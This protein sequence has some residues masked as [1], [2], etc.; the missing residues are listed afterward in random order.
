MRTTSA[1][2]MRSTAKRLG[3]SVTTVSRAITCAP[4]VDPATRKRVL[5]EIS[6]QAVRP[7]RQRRHRPCLGLLLFQAATF[8][9]QYTCG[10]IE[11]LL[12]HADELGI[13]LTILR[14]DPL[15]PGDE[16]QAARRII[17]HR[18]D[19]FITLFATAGQ[20]ALLQVLGDHHLPL[21]AFGDDPGV[22]GIGT[23]RP[24]NPGG[25]RLLMAHLSALGHRRIALLCSSSGSPD[26]RE[27]AQVWRESLAEDGLDQATID[28][29]EVAHIP[30]PLT[31][32]AG[33]T[34]A[35]AAL[36]RGLEASAWI[37]SND[38][39]A[40]GALRRLHEA[41]IAVPRT[42]SVAGFD[43]CRIDDFTIPTLTSVRQPLA[44]MARRA[45][46]LVLAALHADCRQ[47]GSAFVPM[48]LTV[49]ES[50]GP[51]SR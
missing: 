2:S 7:A 25:M 20:A 51:T 4:G 46:S 35:D 11:G 27:R 14:V 28:S 39:T 18:C 41:G 8:V 45:L 6:A 38:E 26:H 37:C 29:L 1:T 5:A 23:I 10:V 21:A 33:W 44:E 13:D 48:T 9:E 24:D 19:G 36:R 43:D 22:S 50:T 34:M 16:G 15:R 31:M 30:I 49:R 42:L 3:L 12:Q 40:I 47:V 32:R 17:E